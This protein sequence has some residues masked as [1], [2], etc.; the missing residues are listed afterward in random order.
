MWISALV[1][2]LNLALAATVG[3]RLLWRTRGAESGPEVWLAGYFLC[4]AF[5]GSMINITVYSSLGPDGLSF[6]A[7]TA[8]ALLTVSTF[9]NGIAGTCVYVFTW[10]TFRARDGWA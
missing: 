3:V 1:T 6:T 8:A 5:F 7:D 9:A 2:L 10:Q 4:G